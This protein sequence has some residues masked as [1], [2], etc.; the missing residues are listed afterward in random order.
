MSRFEGRL[1]AAGDV[2]LEMTELMQLLVSSAPVDQRH[3]VDA[4]ACLLSVSEGWREAKS[5]LDGT[6]APV[7]EETGLRGGKE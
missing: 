5:S 7:A 6:F 1:T 2:P 3:R 4:I